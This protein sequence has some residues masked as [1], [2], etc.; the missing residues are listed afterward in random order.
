MKTKKPAPFDPNSSLNWLQPSG[1]SAWIVGLGLLI[2]LISSG[3]V[4]YLSGGTSHAFVHILYIPIILAGFFFSI[5]GGILAAVVAGFMTGPWMPLD[6]S[7]SMQ[8][9]SYDWIIRSLFFV[10]IGSL[11]G[12]AAHLFRKYLN[13]IESHSLTN[14]VTGLTNLRGLLR[15]F[16]MQ[17]QE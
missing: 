9:F 10:F 12:M 17:S 3:W 13:V 4:I 14:P 16:A 7:L 8:Q 5:L 2:M 6:T 1:W 11:S 15:D